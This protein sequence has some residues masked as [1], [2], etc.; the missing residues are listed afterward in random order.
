MDTAHVCTDLAEAVRLV[1]RWRAEGLCIVMAN[2]CFDLVH[3]GHVCYLRA[4]AALGDRLVVAVNDD[5]SVRRLKGPGRP[6]FPLEQRL[7]LVAAIA[8]VAAVFPFEDPDVTRILVELRPHIHCKGGDYET[9]SAI[10]EYPTAV[11]LGIESRIVGGPKIQSSRGLVPLWR[12]LRE[13]STP[14][15][16]GT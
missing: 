1:R 11:Q 6:V 13:S 3:G 10:P 2:G 14:R 16:E 9:P 8:G 15:A 4:A 12:R 5:A 7:R